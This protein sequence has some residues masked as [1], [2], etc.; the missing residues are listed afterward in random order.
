MFHSLKIITCSTT[1][2]I[3]QKGPNIINEKNVWYIVVFNV[4]TSDIEPKKYDADFKKL[5]E[6][7][8]VAMR[9][10]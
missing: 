5:T 2:G 4:I 9:T 10:M 1:V 3:C 7:S 8:S 6:S